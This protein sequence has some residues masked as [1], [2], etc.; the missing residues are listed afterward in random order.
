MLAQLFTLISRDLLNHFQPTRS[1][2]QIQQLSAC[3]RMARYTYIRLKQHK[4]RLKNTK[5][6]EPQHKKHIAIRVS[7]YFPNRW[8]LSHLNLTKI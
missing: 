6:P 3:D 8:P 7:S 5:Q 4:I 1:N 2:T